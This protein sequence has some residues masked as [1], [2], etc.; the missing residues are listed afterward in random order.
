MASTDVQL[1]E[2]GYLMVFL[3]LMMSRSV[4]RTNIPSRSTIMT[5]ET[6]M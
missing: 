3:T 2:E 4:K 1:V 6:A 5:A